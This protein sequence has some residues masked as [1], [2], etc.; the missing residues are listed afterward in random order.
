[1]VQA[2]HD[3]GEIDEDLYDQVNPNSYKSVIEIP[4][5][6]WAEYEADIR[7]IADAYGADID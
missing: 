4:D 3:M 2:L 5:E 6:I 1:M 7:T